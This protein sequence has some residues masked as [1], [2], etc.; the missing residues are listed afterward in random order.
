MTRTLLVNKSTYI[1]ASVG[2]PSLFAY[3]P[4]EVP[5]PHYITAAPSVCSSASFLMQ[6]FSHPSPLKVEMG[7]WRFGYARA[8]VLARITST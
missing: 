8:G 7:Q 4:P 5:Q 6:S 2:C 3:G 1:W